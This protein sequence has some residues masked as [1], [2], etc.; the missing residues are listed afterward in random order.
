MQK[1]FVV[2]K[3]YFMCYFALFLFYGYSFL[4]FGMTPHTYDWSDAPRI[5]CTA[6]N[7]N[8]GA[9][10]YQ[11]SYEVSIIQCQIRAKPQ[12][13]T[14]FWVLDRNGTTLREG[15]MH[16]DYW[17]VRTVI[18]FSLHFQQHLKFGRNFMKSFKTDLLFGIKLGL[19]ILLHE[20]WA[21]C[22]R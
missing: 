4:R 19:K 16:P 11:S 8:I 17:T 7:N 10:F 15:E 9:Y 21:V 5:H 1:T 13:T 14:A 18:W 3:K 2:W 22:N 20:S 6:W 12:L